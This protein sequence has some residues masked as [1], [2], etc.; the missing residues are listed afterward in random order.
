MEQVQG[1]VYLEQVLIGVGV[2][3]LVALV[4][5]G[6]ATTIINLTEKRGVK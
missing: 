2:F 3:V 1:P 5:I 4:V 6:L